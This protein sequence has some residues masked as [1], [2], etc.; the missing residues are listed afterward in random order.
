MI[1]KVCGMRERENILGLLK[2]P[3]PDWMGMIF[4]PPSSRYVERP[5][6]PAAFYA[7]LPVE[8]VGV[9]VNELPATIKHK[10][11][12]YGLS[13]V[14]LHGDESPE[15]MDR[16]KKLLNIEV[17][18]V[19]RVG[20]VWEWDRVT[21]YLD[22]A[23]WFLFD[24]ETPQYGGSGKRFDWGIIHSYPF[25]RPFL[26]SGGIDEGH[27]EAVLALAKE[28]PMMKGVDINSKFEQAPGLKEL[29]K[30]KRFIHSIRSP[31]HA[32]GEKQ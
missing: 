23:D 31:E 19:F 29:D 28:Q 2:A 25:D 30:V 11:E 17:I 18:K 9:F 22:L 10:V 5:S 16:L 13:K 6:V 15:Q 32:G 20:N 24:T 7:A 14:Q 3:A 26:L 27:M 8:K 12:E 21:P 1:I 4:Y